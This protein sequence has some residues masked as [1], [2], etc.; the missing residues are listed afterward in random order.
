MTKTGLKLERFGK[1]INPDD[2]PN[3][4]RKAFVSDAYMLYLGKCIKN[5]NF[6]RR[7][8]KKIKKIQNLLTS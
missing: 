6:Q 2:D 4:Y 5:L 7:N 3:D 1:K 8:S